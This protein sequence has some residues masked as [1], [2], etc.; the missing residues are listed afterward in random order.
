MDDLLTYDQAAQV[1][2]LKVGTLYSMA[3]QNRLMPP[4]SS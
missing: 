2:N 1:L 3:S 4:L